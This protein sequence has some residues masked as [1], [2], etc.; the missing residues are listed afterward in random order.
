MMLVVYQ[1]VGADGAI[2]QG[3]ESGLSSLLKVKREIG[4]KVAEINDGRG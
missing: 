4:G 2:V 3:E 1:D